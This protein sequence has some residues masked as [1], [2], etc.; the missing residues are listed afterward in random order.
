MDD[1]CIELSSVDLALVR[2][3]VRSEM[4]KAQVVGDD[5]YYSRL[6]MILP[7]LHEQLYLEVFAY[8]P[9]KETFEGFKKHLEQ[10]GKI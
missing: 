1:I 7:K 4:K 10:E 3:V 8:A 2:E 6:K 5:R 9:V